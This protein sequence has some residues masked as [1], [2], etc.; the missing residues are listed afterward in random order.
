MII[1][2]YSQIFMEV[3]MKNYQKISLFI[4]ASTLLS[5]THLS[6]QEIVYGKPTAAATDGGDCQQ[7]CEGLTKCCD[8]ATPVSCWVVPFKRLAAAFHAMNAKRHAKR[9]IVDADAMLAANP[10]LGQWKRPQLLVTLRTLQQLLTTVTDGTTI[11]EQ[12]KQL[13]ADFEAAV[14][15]CIK[16]FEAAN[17]DLTQWK[18]DDLLQELYALRGLIETNIITNET[19]LERLRAILTRFETENINRQRIE[20]ALGGITGN[21]DRTFSSHCVFLGRKSKKE[22]ETALQEL[23]V[24]AERAGKEQ[25]AYIKR[26]LHY[27]KDR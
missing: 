14:I 16:T 13:R 27:C 3:I 22:H 19:T 10:N 24:L 15:S 2:S 21:N 12:L 5:L 1:N 8:A 25:K 17:V 7:P 23:K 11:H 26:I 20:W 9:F 18:N 6:S 4:V